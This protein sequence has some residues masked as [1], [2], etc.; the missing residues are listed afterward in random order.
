MKISRV[1]IDVIERDTGS[2]KVIDER[3]DI[4]GK[5]TQ[6]VLRLLTDDGFEGNAFIGDQASDSS[7]RIKIIEKIIAPKIIGMEVNNREKLW[8]QVEDL[9]G[10][11]LPIYSSWAPVDV[12]LWDLAGKLLNQPIYK[13]LGGDNL[14]IPLYAT[15]PPRHVDSDGFLT[16]AE[17]LLSEGFSAYKIHPGALDI[18]GLPNAHFKYSANYGSGHSGGNKFSSDAKKYSQKLENFSKRFSSIV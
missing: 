17:E 16:E 9:S 7:D 5:T 10:H 4:G 13:L 2:L 3:S 15:F 1:V 11:G 18:K 6:G 8:A 12:A 14:E